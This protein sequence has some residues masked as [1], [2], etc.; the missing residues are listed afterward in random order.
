M[1]PK[2]NGKMSD[3]LETLMRETETNLQ[4]SLQGLMDMARLPEK[5]AK[6]FDFCHGV[7]SRCVEQKFP[8]KIL[9]ELAYFVRVCVYAAVKNVPYE[10]AM[11]E[12]LEHEWKEAMKLA[13]KGDPL[14]Q[15]LDELVAEMGAELRKA[16]EEEAKL[17]TKN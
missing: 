7:L 12:Y 6:V 14:M 9:L 1:N 16:D 10:T 3:A 2:D 8:P 15:I 5:E 17:A 4:T 13:V 11:K